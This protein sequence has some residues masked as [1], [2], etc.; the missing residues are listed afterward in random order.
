MKFDI[1]NRRTNKVQ[2]TAEIDCEAKSISL[3]I[4]LAVKWAIKA[5]ADLAG[6]NLAGAYLVRANL[7]GANLAGANLAGANLAGAY[8]VRANLAGANLAGAS[9]AGA[10][11]VR[12]NLVGANLVRANLVRANLDGANLDGAN[13]PVADIPIIPNIDAAILAEIEKGGK[14]DMG[15]W[16]GPQD[17]WCGTTHCRAGWAVHIAGEKGKAL[18]D[19]VGP[20][21]AGTLIYQASR[22]GK[23]VPWFFMSTEDAIADIRACAAEQQARTS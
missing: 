2:F 1:K 21:L 15:S 13:L 20:Q 14:L 12:A 11:L 23:P 6:A 8:L 19:R 9:L 18:Q 3:K 17:H 5:G 22:P 4:G 10:Y 7:A 16:H